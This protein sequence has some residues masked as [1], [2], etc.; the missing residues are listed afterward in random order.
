MVIY[1]LLIGEDLAWAVLIDAPSMLTS[2]R[3]SLMRF[4]TSAVAVQASRIQRKMTNNQSQIRLSR[5]YNP[6]FPKYLQ[7]SKVAH[8]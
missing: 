8:A 3:S 5:N 2:S 1:H 4:S 7:A 6:F